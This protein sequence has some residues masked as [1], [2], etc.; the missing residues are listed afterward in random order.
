MR[1]RRAETR[2]IGFEPIFRNASKYPF[3]AMPPFGRAPYHLIARTPLQ[4]ASDTRQSVE[5]S[6]SD[7]ASLGIG[8]TR[9]GNGNISGFPLNYRTTI[10]MSPLRYDAKTSVRAGFEPTSSI[11]IEGSVS[12]STVLRCGG[13]IRTHGLL[14]MNQIICH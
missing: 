7:K 1:C 2:A 4:S 10:M 3:S 8:Q 13:G 14:G 9:P 12:C 5:I 11:I 6:H